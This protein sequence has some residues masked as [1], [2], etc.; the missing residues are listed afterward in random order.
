MNYWL[1]CCVFE[2]IFTHA[3]LF[4]STHSSSHSVDLFRLVLNIHAAPVVLKPSIIHTCTVLL[5]K[6]LGCQST[7]L[8]QFCEHRQHFQLCALFS[9]ELWPQFIYQ[10]YYLALAGDDDDANIH[11]YCDNHLIAKLKSNISAECH[12]I[13]F[14]C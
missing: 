12:N 4:R 1:L 13:L 14:K 3:H 6:V 5:R 7:I 8:S 2:H 10:H 9:Y 11:I